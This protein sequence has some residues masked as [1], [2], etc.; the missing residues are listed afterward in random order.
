MDL[1]LLGA[2]GVIVLCAAF[3][4]TNGFHDSANP[5]AVVLGAD[6]R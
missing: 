3:D 1:T 4:Y 2:I 5:I 6:W